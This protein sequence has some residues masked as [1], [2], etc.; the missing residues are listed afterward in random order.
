[1]TEKISTVRTQVYERM[2][3]WLKSNPGCV[4]CCYTGII[5]DS[6]LSKPRDNSPWVMEIPRATVLAAKAF[7]ENPHA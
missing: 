2:L 7:L 6:H 1:M 5:V 4:H 3:E